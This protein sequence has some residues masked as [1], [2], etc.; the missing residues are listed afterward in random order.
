MHFSPLERRGVDHPL[1]RIAVHFSHLLGK[2]KD[3]P[4]ACI[5]WE[6]WGPGLLPSARAAGDEK[7]CG[8]H[9]L[10]QAPAARLAARAFAPACVQ[11]HWCRR[12]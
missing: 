3:V 10:A 4:I 6:A 1:M 8:S 11:L 9:P 7:T 5:S 2:L 12:R